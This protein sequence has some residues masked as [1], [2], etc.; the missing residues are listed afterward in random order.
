MNGDIIDETQG[1]SFP[2]RVL[3]HLKAPSTMGPEAFFA[4]FV[5]TFPGY[6]A[7]HVLLLATIVVCALRFMFMYDVHICYIHINNRLINSFFHCNFSSVSN[8]QFHFWSTMGSSS[9]AR[10]CG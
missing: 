7:E 8:E 2:G 6:L 1:I 4:S 3:W 10:G 5:A 9:S